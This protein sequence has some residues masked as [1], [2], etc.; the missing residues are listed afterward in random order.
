MV[1]DRLESA[2]AADLEPAVSDQAVDELAVVQDLV[3]TAKLAVPMVQGVEAVRAL[4]DDLLHTVAAEVADV[5]VDEFLEEPFLA[6]PPCGVP[7]RALS[8]PSTLNLT[9]ARWR[10]VATARATRRPRLSK[11]PAHPTQ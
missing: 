2:V 6:E 10:T 1:G 8:G 5:L 11:A 9:P 7:R 4:G 3:V